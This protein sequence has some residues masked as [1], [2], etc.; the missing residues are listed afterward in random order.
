[1]AY[2]DDDLD[3]AR[4]PGPSTRER[5]RRRLAVATGGL[6]VASVV[7][8]GTLAWSTHSSSTTAS[9]TP[10]TST[11]TTPSGSSKSSST[12]SSSSSSAT[13]PSTT[14]QAPAAT[15]SGS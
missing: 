15:S 5:G 9:T 12:N 10:S 13:T 4:R 8:A 1:M 2:P 6:A 11:S 3:A 14:Q 7:G